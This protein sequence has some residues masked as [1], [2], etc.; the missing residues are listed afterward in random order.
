MANALTNPLNDFVS[1]PGSAN[2]VRVPPFPDLGQLI[3]T[4]GFKS[5]LEIYTQQVEEWRQRLERILSQLE[6]GVS[7]ATVTETA[8]VE[9]I[10]VDGGNNLSATGTMSLGS[11][12]DSGEVNNLVLGFTPGLAL[13]TII[14]P[15]GGENLYASVVDGSLSSA[16]F[17]FEIGPGETDSDGYKLHYLLAP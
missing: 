8:P 9:S 7:Q 5:G 2:P 12:V 17:R 13:L 15:A 10:Q 3:E 14:K 6:S 1:K 11:G 16:G 4:A